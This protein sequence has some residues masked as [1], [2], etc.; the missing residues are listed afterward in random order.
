MPIQ[1]WGMQTNEWINNGV[2]SFEKL[3]RGLV[4]CLR[5]S[6]ALEVTMLWLTRNYK[7]HAAGWSSGC[8]R[9]ADFRRCKFSW[10]G[11]ATTTSKLKWNA[12][13]RVLS[14]RTRWRVLVLAFLSCKTKLN[15]NSRTKSSLRDE[16]GKQFGVLLPRCELWV[17]RSVLAGE[18]FSYINIH[19]C[20]YEYRRE[21]GDKI[22]VDRVNAILWNC[23]D[24]SKRQEKI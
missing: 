14:Q 18:E 21:R 11:W 16:T 5:C 4:A 22:L 15:I 9:C 24:W 1:K 3:C 23:A 10:S 17:F 7:S 2:N 20:R 19:S 12:G 13:A 6:W 8:N